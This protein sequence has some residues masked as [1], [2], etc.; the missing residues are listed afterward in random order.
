MISPAI[1]YDKKH[2][3]PFLL[4]GG[5]SVMLHEAFSES[6]SYDS[7]TL[8]PFYQVDWFSYRRDLRWSNG[9]TNIVRLNPFALGG[10]R[11]GYA[12]RWAL[13]FYHE[14]RLTRRYGSQDLLTGL[15]HPLFF[16]L[17]TWDWYARWW[18]QF[19]AEENRLDFSTARRQLHL[20]GFKLDLGLQEFYRF[21]LAS[22]AMISRSST[23][24]T[25]GW[26]YLAA[27]LIILSMITAGLWWFRRRR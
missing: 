24:A 7:A 9:F 16:D 23:W 5:R 2:A 21:D 27:T 11:F 20:F 8:A 4:P 26:G 1:D 18:S 25:A 10:D 15:R 3:A 6:G 13:T 19:D 22:G 12:G 14:G 17:A